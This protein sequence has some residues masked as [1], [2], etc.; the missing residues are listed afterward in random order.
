MQSGL[1]AAPSPT[2]GIGNFRPNRSKYSLARKHMRPSVARQPR[3]TVGTAL[4]SK[5][6]ER[7]SDDHF[8]EHLRSQSQPRRAYHRSEEHTSELQSL[9][10]ISYAAFCWKNNTEKQKT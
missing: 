7:Q 9:M 1:H 10:S 3:A 2:T 8:H 5:E 6:Y 4:C